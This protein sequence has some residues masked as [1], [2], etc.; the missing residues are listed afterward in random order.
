MHHRP[1]AGK[2]PLRVERRSG[3]SRHARGTA[4]RLEWR[5][6]ADGVPAYIGRREVGAGGRL[7][8]PVRSGRKQP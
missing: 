1:A 7:A 2:D 5:V 3:R 8:N 4:A 6:A